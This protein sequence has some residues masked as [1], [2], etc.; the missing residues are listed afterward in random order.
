V[1]FNFKKPQQMQ[2]FTTWLVFTFCALLQTGFSQSF[3]GSITIISNGREDKPYEVNI[4]GNK[5]IVTVEADSNESVTMIRDHASEESTIL[6]SKGDMKYG[7]SKNKS[8]DADHLQNEKYILP[9]NINYEITRETRIIDGYNCVRILIESPL[10]AAEAWITKEIPLH[11]SLYYPQLLGSDV[12]PDLVPLRQIADREGFIMFYN[13]THTASAH[14]S[15]IKVSVEAKELTSDLF[16]V[17]SQYLV[18]DEEGMKRL[19]M[20]SQT[21]PARKTQWDEFMIL[22]GK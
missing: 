14:N 4:L 5:S 8:F 11:L 1:F 10:A 20:Q 18:L 15:E 3:E 16:H 6:K 7:F 22:F 13:D 2:S 19:Y 9:K 17:T 21:D 12:N